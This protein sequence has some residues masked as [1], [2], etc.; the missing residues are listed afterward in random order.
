VSDAVRSGPPGQPA[1]YPLRD[2]QL[3][4]TRLFSGVDADHIA[5]RYSMYRP[6]QFMSKTIQLKGV[7]T[8][9]TTRIA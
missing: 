8:A 1:K 7:V 9:K 5:K 3:G 4:E 2:M 6:M